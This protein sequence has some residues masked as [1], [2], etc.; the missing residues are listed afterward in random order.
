MDIPRDFIERELRDLDHCHRR[1][2]GG[3][4]R[5]LERVVDPGSGLDASTRR[6]L[7]GATL[8]RRRLLKFGSVGVLASAAL[9]A[10]GSSGT[11]TSTSAGP[12]TTTRP[13]SASDIA[14]LRTANSIEALA[15]EVYQKA[16]DSGLVTTASALAAIRLFQG[17]HTEHGSLFSR[18]TIA[19]GGQPFTTPNP[20]LQQQVVAPRL[21]ALKTETDVLTLAYDVENLAAETYQSNVGAFADPSLNTTIMQVGGIEA[22]HVA[23]WAAS[24]GKPAEPDG[25][26]QAVTNAV[27]PGT[28]V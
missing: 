2:I 18:T 12:T 27:A 7:L 13:L 10:C 15:V 3:Y 9:A 19:A 28:G 25:A 5:A 16:L 24:T 6:E 4:R 11:S 1:I 17:Q 20:A 23:V 21:A 14:I 22:R 26:F 8:P